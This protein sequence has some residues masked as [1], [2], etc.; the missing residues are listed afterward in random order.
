MIRIALL[1]TIALVGTSASA[2]MPLFKPTNY[3]SNTYAAIYM[4]KQCGLAQPGDQDR[5]DYLDAW[6]AKH[7]RKGSY[8]SQT[9]TVDAMMANPQYKQRF[10]QAAQARNNAETRAKWDENIELARIYERKLAA[11]ER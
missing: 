8:S 7:D 6:G 11:G 5:L 2:Q 9:S 10:C 1:A 4:V 3:A